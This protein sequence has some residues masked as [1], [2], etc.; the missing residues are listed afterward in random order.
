M[1]GKILHQAEP[2]FRLFGPRG[3]GAAKRSFGF[4][5]LVGVLVNAGD[6]KMACRIERIV[7][8]FPLRPRDRIGKIFGVRSIF[9][10]HSTQPKFVNV[11]RSDHIQRSLR[12]LGPILP[13]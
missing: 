1:R 11:F 6:P 12:F 8:H 5:H 13:R 7:G 10:G 3:H 9:D 2:G 4:R